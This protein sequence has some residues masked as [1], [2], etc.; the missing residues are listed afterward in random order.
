LTILNKSL[1][2]YPTLT[3]Q[4]GTKMS[5]IITEDLYKM[6]DI[7]IELYRRGATFKCNHVGEKWVIVITGCQE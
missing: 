3:K 4:T 5:K 1:K 2:I 6:I 7:T